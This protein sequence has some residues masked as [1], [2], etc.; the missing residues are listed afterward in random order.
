MLLGV[1]PTVHGLVDNSM[2]PLAEGLT[3]VLALARAAAGR[4]DQRHADIGGGGGEDIGGVGDNHARGRGGGSVDVVIAYAE[5]AQHPAAEAARLRLLKG[6]GGE[7]IPKGRQDRVIGA[8]RHGAF[9]L[10]HAA[11]VLTD[12][13]VE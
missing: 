2:K 6:S 1:D 7:L 5:I 11:A 13:Q 12:R 9:V 4:K 3:S 10:A 8:E